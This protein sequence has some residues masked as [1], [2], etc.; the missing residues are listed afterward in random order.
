MYNQIY[1]TNL[2]FDD[3][4]KENMDFIKY[5]DEMYIKEKVELDIIKFVIKHF[6]DIINAYYDDLDN[7]KF[8]FNVYTL[9]KNIC[10]I[11][12]DYR[13]M[14]HLLGMNAWKYIDDSKDSV[15]FNEFCDKYSDF[16]N[17]LSNTIM[18]KFQTMFEDYENDI[19]T[20]EK[21]RD[22]N[23][24]DSLNWIRIA[25]KMFC[26][27]NIGNIGDINDCTSETYFFT[28]VRGFKEKKQLYILRKVLSNDYDNSYILLSF[29][30][31]KSNELLDP[32]SIKLVH[33][34]KSKI[35][36]SFDYTIRKRP[37]ELI[38]DLRYVK[39]LKQINGCQIEKIKKN[40]KEMR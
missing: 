31:D 14:A 5:N 9:D 16:L 27:L 30:M 18:Q 36:R 17:N 28:G 38:E 10:T 7:E 26:V 40:S 34:D 21:D 1:Q 4:K 22:S 11:Q 3:T 15:F 35:T 13:N 39:Y 2:P 23:L 24:T 33:V 12:F 32:E 19:L 37:D 25:Y 29:N 8:V 6:K 20:F